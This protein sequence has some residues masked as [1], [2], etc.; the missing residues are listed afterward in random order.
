MSRTRKIVML[1]AATTLA[2]GGA[3]IPT[4][5]FAAA[6]ARVE[7]AQAA[8]QQHGLHVNDGGGV[9]NNIP[10]FNNTG[11]FFGGPVNNNIPIFNNGGGLFGGGVN[12]NIPV[13]NN[14][15]GLFGGGVNNNIPVFNN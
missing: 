10:V 1:T 7:A 9:N 12:N 14:G 4:S 5:A 11:G 3:L 8:P 6:P 13:F 15:G 2:A